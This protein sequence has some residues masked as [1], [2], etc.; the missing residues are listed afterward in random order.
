MDEI[1]SE[2]GVASTEPAGTAPTVANALATDTAVATHDGESGSGA[3][4]QNEANPAPSAPSEP[5]DSAQPDTP[6][7]PSILDEMR[8]ELNKIANMPA[9]IWNEI[10]EAFERVAAKL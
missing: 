5:L 2:Q 8:A 9:H 3:D 4:A 10:E 1:T 6:A 7:D